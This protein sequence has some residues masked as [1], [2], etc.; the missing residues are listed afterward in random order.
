MKINKDKCLHGKCHQVCR[1]AC[2]KGAIKQ[3]EAGYMSIA[4]EKC[5]KCRTCKT[6]C[7]YQAV[8]E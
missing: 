3:D 7:T 6:V 2:P 4:Q 8:E 1:M 5:D